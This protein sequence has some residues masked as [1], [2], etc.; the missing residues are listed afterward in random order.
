MIR[1]PVLIIGGSLV[2]LSQSLFLS[3]RGVSNVVIEKHRGSSLHPRATGFTEHTLEFYRAVGIADQIPENQPDF[4]LRRARVE[5]LTGKI[6]EE[7]PWTP[8]RP[9]ERDGT[10]SPSTGAAIAQD[11]LEPIL[12]EAASERGAD[13]RLGVEMLSFT[14]DKVGVTVLVRERDTQEEYEIRADYMIAA[15][16]ADSSIRGQSGIDRRGVGALRTLQSV[17]FRCPEADAW[18]DRG[19]RQFEIEQPDFKAF[20][21]TYNDGRWFVMFDDDRKREKEELETAIRRALG[22]ALPF[23]IITFGQWELAGRVAERYRAG[24]V[25]LVGDAAHQLPPT[26]GGYGANTGIDDAYN[27]AWKLERVLDG[28]SD[29]VLLD[30]YSEERQPIGWLRH[31]QTFARPDYASWVGDALKGEALYGNMAME[32]GQLTRSSAIIGAGPELPPAAHPD[33]WRGQPGTRAPHV[34]IERSGK[35]LSTIDLFTREFTLMTA[36]PL[37]TEKAN[38]VAAKAKLTLNTLLVGR[39]VVFPS[40][41]AFGVAFGTGDEGASVIRPDGLVAWRSKT[42]PDDDDL[43]LEQTLRQVAVIGN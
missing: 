29:A 9:D 2:G 15:D 18:L 17:L 19:I 21:S 1:T 27:L 20:L 30:T 35:R 43:E 6:I 13:L 12:R 26:R 11:R 5:S 40:G 7:L 28:S 10:L 31:Q 33:E 22:K 8:G 3:W 39:D 14:Q 24:R 32:L 25:F 23:E 37:W 4:R 42:T 34:W 38:K 41:N 36:N 16:G